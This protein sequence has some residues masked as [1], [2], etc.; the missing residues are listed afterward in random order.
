MRSP[1]E[2]VQQILVVIV[3]RSAK[4]A[5][6]NIPHGVKSAAGQLPGVPAAY[7]PEVG[8][9]PVIPQLPPVGGFVQQG[10]PCAGV[11]RGNMLGLDIQ[12]DFAE[13]KIGADACGGSDA[14]GFPDLPQDPAGQLIGGHI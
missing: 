6:G 7:P 11:V 10:D 4:G 3:P 9:G 2:P 5:A 8:D 13:V 14:H 1:E 12:G